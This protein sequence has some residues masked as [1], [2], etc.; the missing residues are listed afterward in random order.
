MNFELFANTAYE[1]ICDYIS[2]GEYYSG[3]GIVF[4]LL[5]NMTLL[6][7]FWIMENNI[8]KARVLSFHAKNIIECY[9]PHQLPCFLEFRINSCLIWS[10]QNERDKIYLLKN[11]LEKLGKV[12]IDTM[13]FAGFL[14][15]FEYSVF[16]NFDTQTGL[17]IVHKLNDEYQ[18]LLRD[19]FNEVARH[20]DTTNIPHNMRALFHATIAIYKVR[21]NQFFRTSYNQ[22][23]NTCLKILHN[24]NLEVNTWVIIAVCQ[25]ISVHLGTLEITQQLFNVSGGMES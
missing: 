9:N 16:F 18:S 11:L 7:Y 2:Q 12:L 1:L 6:I 17:P 13:V 25:F 24:N 22:E 4:A 15:V 10:C 14:L 3:D 23:F 20:M 8:N 5:D 21:S 19:F